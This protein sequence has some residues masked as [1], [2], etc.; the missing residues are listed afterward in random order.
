MALTI[1]KVPDIT[2]YLGESGVQRAYNL[3]PS[4]SDYVTGGYPITASAVE[5]G[6]LIGADILLTN[7]AGA[8]YLASL[9]AT[10]LPLN[11]NPYQ[12]QVNLVVYSGSTQVA[13][14]TDLSAASWTAL[15]LGW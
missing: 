14:G 12:N 3:Q 7:P 15:F 1:T 6:K 8:A 4:P 9:V 10:T 13:A 5:L 11:T 2:Y